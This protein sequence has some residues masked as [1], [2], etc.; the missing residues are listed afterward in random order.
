MRVLLAEDRD[1]NVRP[2]VLLLTKTAHEDCALAY[3][4]EGR[5]LVACLFLRCGYVGVCSLMKVTSSLRRPSLSAAQAAHTSGGG[6][7][8]S[9]ASKDARTV[10]TMA[11]LPPRQRPCQA[12]FNPG[13]IIIFLHT[14]ARVLVPACKFAHLFDLVAA[15]SWG[16]NS[17]GR[18]FLHDALSA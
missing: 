9:S 14:Q 5:A 3:T 1:Q 4:L 16:Y 6:G 8:P 15:T 10:M 17:A 18:L 11:F 13:A 7:Y 2:G 12:D